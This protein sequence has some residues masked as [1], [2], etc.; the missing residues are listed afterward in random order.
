[1]KKSFKK[2]ICWVLQKSMRDIKGEHVR[3]PF[4]P[5]VTINFIF[6]S[7]FKIEV[8]K[9]S[10]QLIHEFMQFFKCFKSFY[11][12]LGFNLYQAYSKLLRSRYYKSIKM[13][14]MQDLIHNTSRYVYSKQLMILSSN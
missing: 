7:T 10:R 4:F 2:I 12:L 9:Y 11:N 13:K 3:H 1:M 6:K 5:A 8:M 14:V